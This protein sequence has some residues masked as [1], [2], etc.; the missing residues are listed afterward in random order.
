MIHVVKQ[1]EA[2]RG[3][4]A[5]PMRRYSAGD[6]PHALQVWPAIITGATPMYTKIC[7]QWYG[8]INLYSWKPAFDSIHSGMPAYMPLMQQTTDPPVSSDGFRWIPV[9]GGWVPSQNWW[10]QAPTDPVA[11]GMLALNTAEYQYR[12]DIERSSF[13]TKVSSGT[14]VGIF[15]GLFRDFNVCPYE[16][17]VPYIAPMFHHYVSPGYQS[18]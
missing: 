13:T 6:E 7:V 15:F 3:A 12:G 14:P 18:C 11:T 5:A 16:D 9:P 1:I 8:V 2:M 17:R 4:S 10:R